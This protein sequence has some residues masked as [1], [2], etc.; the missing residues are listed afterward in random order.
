M[1]SPRHNQHPVLQL[2]PAVKKKAYMLSGGLPTDS[3]LTETPLFHPTLRPILTGFSILL[4]A[5]LQQS[6][7]MSMV[8][9]SSL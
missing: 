9:H 8:K 3:Q 6:C 5:A 4:T 2:L 7:L 1:P